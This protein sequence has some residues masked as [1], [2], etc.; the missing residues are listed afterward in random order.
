[1]YE[2]HVAFELAAWTE[3]LG[4]TLGSLTEAVFT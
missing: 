3:S 1:M 4:D 2:A